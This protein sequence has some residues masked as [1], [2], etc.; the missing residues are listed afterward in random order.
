[1]TYVKQF[2][3]DG[4]NVLKKGVPTYNVAN[5]LFSN[6]SLP[7][8]KYNTMRIWCPDSFLR[9][10]EFSSNYKMPDKSFDTLLGFSS[11]CFTAE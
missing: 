9:G 1:M 10:E 11:D 8:V 5:K 4:G 7:L 2:G 6:I 3:T